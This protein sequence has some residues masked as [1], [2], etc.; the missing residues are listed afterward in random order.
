MIKKEEYQSPAIEVVAIESESQIMA[1]S[2]NIEYGGSSDDM[3]DE[4]IWA[5]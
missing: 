4:D 3:E 5:E 1:G 2:E